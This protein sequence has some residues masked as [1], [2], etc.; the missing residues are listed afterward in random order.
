VKR[1]GPLLGS[2]LLVIV[3]SL[4]PTVADAVEGSRVA[5]Y[6]V[7][8]VSPDL[9]AAVSWTPGTTA[10]LV[11]YRVEARDVDS[12]EESTS[13]TVAAGGTSV[14]LKGLP[15]WYAQAARVTAIFD[16]GEE[17]SSGWSEPFQVLSTLVLD[18]DDPL[19]EHGDGVCCETYVVDRGFH[20]DAP[21]PIDVWVSPTAVDYDGSSAHDGYSQTDARWPAGVESLPI[22]IPAGT[23]HGKYQILYAGDDWKRFEYVH[24]TFGFVG[25]TY[26]AY[27]PGVVHLEGARQEFTLYEDDPYFWPDVIVDPETEVPAGRTARVRIRL[28]HTVHHRTV[29]HYVFR[30]GSARDGRDF[31]GRGHEVTVPR[32]ERVAYVRVPTRRLGKNV[33]TRSFTVK[34]AKVHEQMARLT[35]HSASTVRISR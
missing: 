2:T 3:G 8:V 18:N 21:M 27:S 20:L 13:A 9:T 10:G 30:D 11:S 16:D 22:K 31:I 14:V 6:G 5:P 33:R 12:G 7:T 34:V 35:A 29:L 1:L 25:V 15:R 24:D 26:P 32:G 17:L 4:V 19:V 23:T 28:N